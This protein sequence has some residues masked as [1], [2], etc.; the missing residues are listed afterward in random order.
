MGLNYL[1]DTNACIA[2]LKKNSTRLVERVESL[3]PQQVCVC[4][5]V[6]AELL[7]GAMK[8][9]NPQRNLES[10]N[11]LLWGMESHPFDDAAANEYAVIRQQLESAGTPI[12]SNDFIIAAIARSRGLTVVTRNTREFCRVPNLLVEDWES[13]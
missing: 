10:L 3:P 9:A 13:D 4:S 1:L 6:R 2:I 8:S 12:G 11:S 7:Y 5:V